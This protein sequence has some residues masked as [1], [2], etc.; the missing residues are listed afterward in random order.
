MGPGPAAP[1]LL[2]GG[3]PLDEWL[4]ATMLERRVVWLRGRL[5]D[6]A[7]TA[8]ATQLMTLDGSGDGA[9]RLHLNSGEGRLGAALTLMDTIAALG[10]PVEAVCT[11]RSEGAALGVLA[12]AHRRQAANHASLR[13]HDEEIEAVGS[14]EQV[15]RELAQRRRQLERFVE[16]VAAACR[17]PAERVEVDLAESRYLEVE[18]ALEYRLIDSIWRGATRLS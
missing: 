2:G 15:S 12:V 4:E 13:F 1:G 7:A 18:E 6:E 16:L 14:A 17:Q 9:I 11:G 10:V 5:D 8:V 3:S